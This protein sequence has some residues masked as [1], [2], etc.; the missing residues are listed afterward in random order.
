MMNRHKC[1]RCG[2]VNVATDET[3][4]RCGEPLTDEPPTEE[5]PPKRRSLLKRVIWVVST[6]VLLLFIAYMSMLITSEDLRYDQRQIVERGIAVLESKGFRKNSFVLKRLTRFRATD[7]WW[8]RYLGHRDAYAAT[9][10][11]F[12]IVTL[13]PEFF[14]V[15]SDD[16][17]RAAI[18]L[19]ESEH[20]LG[21]GEERALE[22]TWRS[23]TQL[24]WTESNY[25]QSRVWNNTKELTQRAL[26][27]LF[28]CGADGKSD[29]TE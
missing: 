26:P 18:L 7:S 5:A 28:T 10:F 22:V 8:N 17:E 21:A 1:A 14:E 2:L 13:Y 3:C 27:N 24:G 16:I 29:C 20:L 23:K 9:N 12:E 25:T 4:R 11:P 15:S 19:H 6:T